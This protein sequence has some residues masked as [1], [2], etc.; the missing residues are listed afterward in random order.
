[1]CVVVFLQ[2]RK[3]KNRCVRYLLT[4]ARLAIELATD[5][6]DRPATTPAQAMGMAVVIATHLDILREQCAQAAGRVEATNADSAA[7]FKARVLL[8]FDVFFA[9]VV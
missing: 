2:K 8:V 7:L 9:A 4:R 1:V 6:F 3:Q 5:G